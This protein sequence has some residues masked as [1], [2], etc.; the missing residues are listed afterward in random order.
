MGRWSAG[1]SSCA[2]ASSP[3]IAERYSSSN[4]RGSGAILASIAAVLAEGE[5]EVPADQRAILGGRRGHHSEHLGHLLAVM[6]FLPRTY[7]DAT[8]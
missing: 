5:L 1:A 7:P 4:S 8:W 3:A 2:S 6:Q